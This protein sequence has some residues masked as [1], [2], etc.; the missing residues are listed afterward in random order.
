MYNGYFLYNIYFHCICNNFIVN[1]STAHS[2]N[3]R[4][5]GAIILLKFFC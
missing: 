5:S 3:A 2:T 1:K 4:P